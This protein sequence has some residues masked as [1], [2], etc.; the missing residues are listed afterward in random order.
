MYTGTKL[1]TRIITDNYAKRKSM[2]TRDYC[3]SFLHAQTTKPEWTT[4]KGKINCNLLLAGK[5]FRL[6][7]ELFT[8]SDSKA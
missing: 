7:Y 5:K 2:A 3:N 4:S 1:A 8:N 6:Q